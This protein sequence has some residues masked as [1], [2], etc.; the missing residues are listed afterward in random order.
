MADA[1][2]KR[3]QANGRLERRLSLIMAGLV[4][5][6]ALSLGAVGLWFEWGAINRGLNERLESIA[7]VTA[8]QIDG[9][10]HSRIQSES[11]PAYKAMAA[12]LSAVRESQGLLYVYTVV[13]SGSNDA[14][15]V[16]DGSAEP[17]AIG[18]TPRASPSSLTCTRSSRPSRAAVSSRNAIISRN[19]H[20]VSTCS[21]GNGGLA[22]AKAFCARCSIAL[23][24]LPIEYSMTGF[25]N[26]ATASRMIWMAS[27]S[28]RRKRI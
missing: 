16:V 20:V 8:L 10:A 3:S 5:L 1:K 19:F 17:E 9:D 11:D 21:S 27:A 15:L 25:L 22:G 26:S 18:D 13:R 7:A 14:T 2:S 6:S 4:A 24:S 12:T 28:R 23:E